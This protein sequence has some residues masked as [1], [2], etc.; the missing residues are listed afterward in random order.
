M[1]GSKPGLVKKNGGAKAPPFFF[2]KVRQ[3]S[4]QELQNVLLRL[5]GK[6]ERRGRDRLPGRE[7]LAVGRF[8]VGVGERQVGRAGLQHVDQVLVEVLADL[9]DRQV[10]AEG[11][12]LRA[13]RDAGGVERRQNIVGGVVV[14][15]VGAGG[16]AGQAETC[17]I[18]RHAGDRRARFAGFVEHQLQLVSVEQVDAVEGGVLRGGGDLRQ[19]LVVLGNQAGARGLRYRVGGWRRTRAKC[20][21]TSAAKRNRTDR[22]PSR[23]VGRGKDEVVVAVDAGRQIARCQGSIQ[24]SKR[25]ASAEG[26]GE[27]RK[28]PALGER[29]RLVGLNIGAIN[30][31]GRS[32]GDRRR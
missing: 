16:E 19:D 13:Q 28:A 1:A 17:R 20:R 9:H 15:E 29:D 32:A 8:L 3:R 10:G 11:G 22:G 12:G 6:R 24:L 5:V 30:Q 27:R 2:S 14:D 26:D 31:I 18:E 25:F 23:I 7:R 21:R 4:A